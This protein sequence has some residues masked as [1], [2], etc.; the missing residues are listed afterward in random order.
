MSNKLIYLKQGI[1]LRCYPIKQN[2]YIRLIVEDG[3]E[4]IIEII[5]AEVIT[6]Q[7][8][9]RSLD[10]ILLVLHQ[11]NLF[12]HNLTTGRENCIPYISFRLTQGSIAN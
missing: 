5:M 10:K 8:I 9:M 7:I 12:I 6:E 4:D 2:Y 11:D 1:V 3:T